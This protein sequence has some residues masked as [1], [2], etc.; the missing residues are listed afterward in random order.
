MYTVTPTTPGN[1][2]DHVTHFGCAELKM[3]GLGEEN[4]SCPYNEFDYWDKN[5]VLRTAL[6]NLSVP[7]PFEREAGKV[8]FLE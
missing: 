2:R 5:G 6:Y 3:A 4:S 1:R 7:C 8:I